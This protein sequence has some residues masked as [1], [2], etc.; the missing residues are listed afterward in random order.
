VVGVGNIYACE[1]LNRSKIS[2]TRMANKV[3]KK[4]CE[5]LVK[6]IKSILAEAIQVGG[7]SLRDFAGVDGTLGYFIHQFKVYDKEGKE[8]ECGG[9]IERLV[10]G[11]R[12]TFWCKSCQK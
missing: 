8:C 11:G 6:E 12:S 1:A 2:P 9:T 3:K 7:S 5:L 4:E 10:Q